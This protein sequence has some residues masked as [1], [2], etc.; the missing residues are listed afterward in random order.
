MIIS[1][2]GTFAID[3]GS[4]K[5]SSW[6]LKFILRQTFPM[7]PAG[8]VCNVENRRPPNRFGPRSR[9]T[10]RR[11]HALSAGGDSDFRI[12]GIAVAASSEYSNAILQSNA[13]SSLDTPGAGNHRNPADDQ[14]G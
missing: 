5:R 4:K 12:Y 11:H 1:Q 9:P 2:S 7:T 13:G 14:P 10:P 3:P 8:F 6:L